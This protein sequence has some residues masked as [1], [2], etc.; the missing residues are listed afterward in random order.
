[1][2]FEE[3]PVLSDAELDTKLA[4]TG[5]T[6]YFRRA[7]PLSFDTFVPAAQA[8]QDTKQQVM[9]ALLAAYNKGASATYRYVSVR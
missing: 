4:P 3:A 1:M 8:K 7:I 2:S 5:R 6:M 9:D